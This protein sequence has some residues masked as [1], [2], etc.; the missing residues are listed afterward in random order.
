MPMYWGNYFGDTRHLSRAQHGSYL[1]LIGH[2]WMHAG[3]P[4]DDEQLARIA[5]ASPEEWKADRRVLQLFFHDGWHHK[6][7]DEELRRYASIRAARAVAG[8]KGG[9]VSAINRWKRR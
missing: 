7:I 4:D 1:L 3:L 6:R 5:C 2:Y 9:T 8:S